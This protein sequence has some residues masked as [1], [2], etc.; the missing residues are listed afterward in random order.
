MVLPMLSRR[1]LHLLGTHRQESRFSRLS[2]TQLKKNN[3]M[4]YRYFAEDEAPKQSRLAVILN[5][6]SELAT[7][8][9]GSKEG[10]TA[11]QKQT[12][13]KSSCGDTSA[14]TSAKRTL[15]LAVESFPATPVTPPS[16]NRE[17]LLSAI[18]ATKERK[19]SGTETKKRP[20]PSRPLPDRTALLSAIKSRNPEQTGGRDEGTRSE[21]LISND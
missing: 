5:T 4:L 19:V 21:Y 10:W 18:K 1:E 9:K 8:V 2:S 13:A 7:I 6:L 11:K 20:A 3:R 17:R 14:S 15:P 16:S 12:K